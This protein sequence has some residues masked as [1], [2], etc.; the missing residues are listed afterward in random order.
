MF[1]LWRFRDSHRVWLFFSKL[2][3]EA[4]HASIL[5]RMRREGKG[6]SFHQRLPFDC[7]LVSR[8][9]AKKNLPRFSTM[10]PIGFYEER[11]MEASGQNFSTL[12]Y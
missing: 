8:K 7:P 10:P 3:P 2:L 6:L 1:V 5:N 11:E 4:L 9:T 12:V